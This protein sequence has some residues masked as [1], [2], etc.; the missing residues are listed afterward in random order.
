MSPNSSPSPSPIKILI[1][2]DLEQNRAFARAAL[3]DEGYEVILA[4]SGE[5]GIECFREHAPDCVLLDAR[6]PGLDG[7]ATCARIRELP[8]GAE[9]P[10][11]FLTAQRDLDT[12]DSALQAGAD[13][14]LTKPVRPT[15]LLLR[16][17]ASL[18][19]RRAYASNREYV[20]LLRQQ[21]DDL[22]RLQLQKERLMGFV[23][24][25][26]KNPVSN[27]DLLAQLLSRD[28]DSA[29][30]RDAGVHIRDEVRSLMRLLLNLLDLSKSEEGR[31]VPARMR[32]EL[33]ELMQ[34]VC[35][36]LAGRARAREVTLR[37]VIEASVLDADQ[38]LVRRVLENLL[39]N[40]LRHAPPGST[41]T[42]SACSRAGAIE[43]GVAD[44]GEGVP[45]ALREAIFDR[46][47][48]VNKPEHDA[49]RSGRGLG[50][51][52]CRLAVEAH[53]GRIW[54][55]DAEPGARF[56]LS[57]PNVE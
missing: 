30:A 56:M 46:F 57:I 52:F 32:I 50:L 15:E 48:Q 28:P 41:V 44:A 27:I 33:A 17:R 18:K 10:V 8:N 12:F 6:M 5:E 54:V 16:V 53:G 34:G 20:D 3:E 31:L 7:F 51:A 14:F 45:P 39:E 9:T 35:D 21:R 49:S 36:A 2:D 29:E 22:M 40:A 42:V 47:V 23:V 26:L 38:D 1:I 25:D 43:L 55:E 4:K 13:D 37:Q 11:V 19:L 24:H